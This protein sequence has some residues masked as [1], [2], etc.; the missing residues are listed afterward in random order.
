MRGAATR[1]MRGPVPAGTLCLAADASR[2]ACDRAAGIGA[3]DRLRRPP[4]VTIVRGR[5]ERSAARLAH[6]SG[7]LG[8]PS[9]NLG[10][11]TNN[12]LKLRDYSIAALSRLR[13]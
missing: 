3:G 12:H 8:V 7:G 9:S 11:P 5:S 13:S 4:P 10:A 1:T 6:Q 2:A